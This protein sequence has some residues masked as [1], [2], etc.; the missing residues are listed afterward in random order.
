MAW[1]SNKEFVLNAKATSFYGPDLL[2]ALNSM[3]IPRD[4]FPGFSMGGLVRAMASTMPHLAGGGQAAGVPVT[5][6]IDRQRFNVSAT[7]DTVKALSRFAVNSQI[8]SA[9]RKPSWVR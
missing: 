1:L 5:F 4:M 9:G 8:S 3:R 7:E 2:H 6:V